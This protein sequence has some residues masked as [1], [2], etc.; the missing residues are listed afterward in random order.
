MAIQIA[1]ATLA[2]MLMAAWSSQAAERVFDFA[3]DKIDSPPAGFHS[4]VAGMGK[5]GDWRIIQDAAASQ[6]APL[7]P[8]A[9]NTARQ[10][11]LAQLARDPT[12]EH[13]PMLIYD[14]ETYGDF[15]LTV[16]FKTVA[17]AVEQMAGIAFRI[18]DEKNFYVVRASSLGNTFR[19]YRVSKGERDNPIGP[20]MEI[21][22][23]TWHELSVECQGNRIRL[24]LDGK[25][26]MP[27]LTDNSFSQ[28]KIGFWTKSDSVS[29]F[30]D[31]KLVYTPREP[32]AQAFVREALEKF[33]R[34]VGIRIYAPFGAQPT[35]QVI[36]SNLATDLH[37]PAG[38][39]EADCVAK[40]AIFYGKGTQDLT[41]TLPLHDRNGEAVAAVRL[42]MRSF[43]GQTEVNAIA[44]AKPI[45]DVLEAKVRALK[46]LTD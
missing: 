37:K 22:K 38:Q 16:R 35:M 46:D 11:V 36:A 7:S 13:F 18:Q 27:E 39:V 24:R 28:G 43:P 19:F 5:P 44:R 26:A 10:L 9:P 21:P 25:E 4:T 8:D 3:K 32:L 2:A 41:I 40:N 31:L 1:S 12:D 42:V 20:D 29:Y 6:F 33:P 15:T 14:E 34:V 17:G 23:G 30:A 45:V